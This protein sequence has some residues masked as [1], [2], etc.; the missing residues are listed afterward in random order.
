M[1]QSL[2][3]TVAEIYRASG[4]ALKRAGAVSLAAG[5]LAMGSLA[6]SAFEMRPAQAQEGNLSSGVGAKTHCTEP[7]SCFRG[8]FELAEQGK[9]RQALGMY[10]RAASLNP[11]ITNNINYQP[12]YISGMDHKSKKDYAMA[13]NYFKKAIEKDPFHLDTYIALGTLYFELKQKGKA[14]FFYEVS[15]LFPQNM[16][17]RNEINRRLELLS[18]H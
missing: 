15:L 12:E 1:H 5:A 8:G 14:R 11:P 9:Y 18:S 16:M 3:Q 13:E 17:H 7:I 4:S 6:Y 2:V 10:R